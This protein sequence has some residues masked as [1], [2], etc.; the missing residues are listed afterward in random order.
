MCFIEVTIN[1]GALL[2]SDIFGAADCVVVVDV[3]DVELPADPA[4]GG[5]VLVVVVV[6]VELLDGALPADDPI[7]P[8]ALTVPVR[9]TL[10]P[11][12]FVRSTVP[13]TTR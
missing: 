1:D 2:R 4:D 5:V 7:P 3:D 10:C 9:A 8:D 12:C 6:C 13:G 11:T